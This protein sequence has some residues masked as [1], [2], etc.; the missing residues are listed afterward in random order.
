MITFGGTM[1]EQDAGSLPKTSTAARAAG[2]IAPP[3]SLAGFLYDLAQAYFAERAAVPGG[4][5]IERSSFVAFV[6]AGGAATM[7]AAA[8]ALSAQIPGARIGV[9]AAEGLVGST[10]GQR[11]GGDASRLAA[12]LVGWN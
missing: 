2:R 4:H 5:S 8:V 12:D 6:T 7:G 10:W 11:I 9:L 3:L 1:V